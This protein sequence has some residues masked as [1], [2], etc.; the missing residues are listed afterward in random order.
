MT[1]K[2][3]ISDEVTDN[4]AKA[5]RQIYQCG[6]SVENA[7]LRIRETIPMSPQIEYLIAFITKSDK[8]IIGVSSM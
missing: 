7:L 1:H 4:I 2:G 5:Y 8:G 6:T 3:G